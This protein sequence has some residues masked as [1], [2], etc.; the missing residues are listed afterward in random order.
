MLYRTDEDQFA[1]GFDAGQIQDG[2]VTLD[3][4][5]GELVI[6]GD[7]GLAFSLQQALAKSV[8]KRVRV[9]C[10]SMEAMDNLQKMLDQASKS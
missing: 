1:N 8:G 10:V 5:T 4:S 9:S 3:E 7:D 2:V 6:V